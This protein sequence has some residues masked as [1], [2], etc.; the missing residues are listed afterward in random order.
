VPRRNLGKNRIIRRLTERNSVQNM[1]CMFPILTHRPATGMPLLRCSSQVALGIPAPRL[2]ASMPGPAAGPCPCQL[3]HNLP[4][5]S[6]AAT[7]RACNR[8]VRGQICL[9]LHRC[10]PP[11]RCS[12][13]VAALMYDLCETDPLAGPGLCR[14]FENEYYEKVDDPAEGGATDAEARAAAAD[15][16]LSK[17]SRAL[18][19]RRALGADVVYD[20]EA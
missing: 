11:A 18:A 19:D 10:T 6:P 5:G 15:E 20:N 9:L 17:L 12:W 16:R 13:Y 4:S 1:L 3:N 8:L 14:H 7:Y 2:P